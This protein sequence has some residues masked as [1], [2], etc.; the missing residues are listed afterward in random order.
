MMCYVSNDTLNT[1]VHFLTRYN[2]EIPKKIYLK[3]KSQHVCPYMCDSHISKTARP[4]FIYLHPS[5]RPFSTI[6]PELTDR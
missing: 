6:S 2:I 5:V 1:A 4:N 3:F